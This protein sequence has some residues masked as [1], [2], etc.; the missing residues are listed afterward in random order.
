MSE[1]IK[2]AIAYGG[3]VCGA[4]LLAAKIIWFVP[5]TVLAK[6]LGKIARPLDDIVGGAIEG[7]ISILAACLMFSQLDV[8][9]TLAVPGIVI[10]VTLLWESGK[11]AAYRLKTSVI[12]IVAGYFLHPAIFRYLIARFDL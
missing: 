11:E 9:I 1:T 3:L 4:P 2:I 5:G 7:L 12:A 6:A 8:R 10:A